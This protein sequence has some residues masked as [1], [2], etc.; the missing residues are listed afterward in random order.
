MLQLPF[1]MKANGMPIASGDELDE[2]GQ[3]LLADYSSQLLTSPQEVDIDRFITVYLGMKQDFFYLSHC[4][5]YLGM[6][7]FQATNNIPVFCPETGRAEYASANAGTI[8][9]DNSLA[10][11]AQEHRYRYTAGHEGAHSILHPSYFLNSIR[12]NSDEMIPYMRCRAD[13]STSTVAEAISSAFLWTDERRAEQQANRFASAILMPKCMVKVL[14]AR[15]PYRG[16]ADWI[17]KVT[18]L[19]SET[20]NVSHEAAFYRLKELGFIE[21]TIEYY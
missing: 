18:G 19:I 14:L 8:I 5:A 2:Y 21:K 12:V 7:V 17:C 10:C 9:I 3:R 20:F 16:Q 13:F 11:E 1:R 6:T 15:T 4:G